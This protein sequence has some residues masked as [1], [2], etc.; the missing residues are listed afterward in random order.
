M[1]TMSKRKGLPWAAVLVA[2]LGGQVAVGQPVTLLSEDFDSLASS[3]QP[4]VNECFS[5]YPPEQHASL[6]GWLGVW[7]DELPG[8]T[9][10][11]TGVPGYDQA[12]TNDGATEW[13]GWAFTKRDWWTLVAG[14]QNRSQFTKAV[15]VVAVADPDEWD[16][17]AHPKLYLDYYDAYMTSPAIP[18]AGVPVGNLTLTFDS[19]WRPEGFDDTWGVAPD[20]DALNNQTATITAIYQPGGETIEVLR[21]DSDEAG[22][23]YHP[24]ATNETVT[25]NLQ[26]PAGATS[27][28]LKFGLLKSRNDWWWAIDNLSIRNGLVE[29]A[30]EDF[31]DAPLEPAVDEPPPSSNTW[32][33]NGPSGWVVDRSGVPGVGDPNVGVEEFEGWNFM[34]AGW[35]AYTAQ[36]Q[37]RSGF[38]GGL[39]DI[40]AVADPDEWD[41]LG[42]PDQG[43]TVTFNSW[44]TLPTLDVRSI[45]P[46]TGVLRFQS[47]WRHEDNQTAVV[48][49]KYDDG[50][51][52]EV[53]RWESQPGGYF[54]ADNTNE[55]VEVQL[56]NPLGARDMQIRFGLLNA[57]NNWFWAIDDVEVKGE[58]A[59]DTLKLLIED[60]NDLPFGPCVEENCP[61]GPANV[62]TATPPAGWTVDKTNV[63]GV[64]DPNEGME[65]WEG[66]TFANK[67]WWVYVAGDQERSQFTKGVGTVAIADPDEWDDMGNPD[68]LGTFNSF[69]I[70]PA[71]NISG[72]AQSTLS[73]TFD[74]SWRQEG[75]QTATV[76]VAYDGGSEIEVLRWESENGAP[77]YFHADNTNE[78]VTVPLNNPAGA[79][80]MVIRFGMTNAVNN[81]FW[82]IDNLVVG[83]GSTTYLSENFEGLTLGPPAQE[84]PFPPASVWTDVPPTGWVL[85]DTGVPG[86]DQGIP[87]TLDDTDG[88]T[89]WAGWS[90]PLWSWWYT[91]DNQLRDQFTKATG[92]IAVA[93]PDEWDDQP[94]PPGSYNAWMSTPVI[95]ISGTQIRSLYLSFDSS[96]RSIDEPYENGRMT[97]IIRVRYD[98]GAP[99]QVLRWANYPGW[100]PGSPGDPDFKPDALNE[101]VLLPLLNPSAST[102]Q[103]EFGLVDAGNDWWWAIDNL[104]VFAL[105]PIQPFDLDDDEDVDSSDW[106]I[107]QRCL[108]MELTVGSPAVCLQSDYDKDNVVDADDILSFVRCGS[109]PG[110]PQTDELC[111]EPD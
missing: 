30:S 47:S 15:G 11:D 10:D 6:C 60:F 68:G 91:V 105:K 102:M 51:W 111:G 35:W 87:G 38:F 104:V 54:H 31:E 86:Y 75:N 73:L 4:P 39:N 55:A 43:G 101:S 66:W 106:A 36:D 44:M 19:S 108:N 76:T 3:L 85:D 20:Q 74:S 50:S 58:L 29:I 72:A 5:F 97:A 42:D 7:T 32:T 21:W 110:V 18:I 98:G 49:V 22:S 53:L 14:D 25:I 65:D 52:V 96:W 71:V 88:R 59:S 95:D 93:D 80:S 107:M 40:V 41:D 99:V 103:V 1:M 109:G 37:G 83:D 89:E 56:A 84:P 9:I 13:C 34:N 28:Q 70:T 12:P 17:R 27:V 46:N 57:I 78:T 82:A 94:H 79:T 90:F 23:Y 64:G 62:W 77:A 8:W 92:G 63:P 26:N 33:P 81:W 100:P 24:D 45:A 67:D 16:D 69:L 48:Q 2:V 61:G